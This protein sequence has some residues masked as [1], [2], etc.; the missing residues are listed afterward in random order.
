MNKKLLY[1]VFYFANYSFIKLLPILNSYLCTNQKN[2]SISHIS[3]QKLFFLVFFQKK[4][5]HISNST[6]DMDNYYLS[7][8]KDKNTIC[9][10]SMI[11]PH[12][13]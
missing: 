8:K 5:N 10:I 11:S 13:L 6:M 12:K 1:I 4:N 3:N 2:V 9:L 7:L